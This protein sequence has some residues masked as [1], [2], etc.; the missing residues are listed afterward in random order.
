MKAA[1]RPEAEFLNSPSSIRVALA[2]ALADASRLD[3]A[4]AFVG[5]DWED[6]LGSF[7][8]RVRLV[9]WLSS[10]NT[11]PHAVA[12]MIERRFTVRQLDDMH[13]KV[14]VTSGR[15]AAAIIGSANLSCAALAADDAVGQIEAG[16]LMR[17]PSGIRCVHGWF[18]ALW[19]SAHPVCA[20][21]I[22]RAVRAWESAHRHGG[23]R[24]PHGRR[25]GIPPHRSR[26]SSRAT[27]CRPKPSKAL[28][29]AQAR[30]IP[31]WT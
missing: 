7:N 29:D 21:D 31:Q 17:S 5:R 16:V 3:A 11:N 23:H 22:E 9:C 6:I 4:V 26:P 25:Q 19:R 12:Q 10:T 14:Y 28:R 18:E 8:G 15:S 20:E 1:S 30:L 24:G 27:G 2:A 13:A